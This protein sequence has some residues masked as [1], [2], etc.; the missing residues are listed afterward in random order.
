MLIDCYNIDAIVSRSRLIVI[1]ATRLSRVRTCDI[2]KIRV[3]NTCGRSR[4]YIVTYSRSPTK[5][6]RPERVIDGSWELTETMRSALIR[7]VLA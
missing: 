3:V 4:C 6:I 2:S 5:I 7:E 1:Y